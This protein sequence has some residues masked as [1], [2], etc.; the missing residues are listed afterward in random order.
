MSHSKSRTA[1]RKGL[2]DTDPD[3]RV[4][5]VLRRV[6]GRGGV[7][8]KSQIV[9]RR[10]RAKERDVA[11]GQLALLRRLQRRRDRYASREQL[12]EELDS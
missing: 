7:E 3:R 8:V 11:P 5:Y 6:L 9:R 10:R 2:S 4:K 1:R 12:L